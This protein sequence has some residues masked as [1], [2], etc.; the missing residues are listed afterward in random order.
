L[1]GAPRENMLATEATAW[2]NL[3]IAP[4]DTV[5]T[6]MAHLQASVKGLQVTLELVGESRDPVATSP[7]GGPEL[8]RLAG[9]VQAVFGVPVASARAAAAAGS[10]GMQA[11]AEHIYCFLPR[12][13]SRAEVALSYGVDE[14]V[15]I[16]A[17]GEMIRFYGTLLAAQDGATAVSASR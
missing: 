12:R 14:R 5:A 1:T 2:I 6:V 11:I 3:R 15:G 10:R 4:G 8:A 16:D 13:R 9:A 17:L 7:A